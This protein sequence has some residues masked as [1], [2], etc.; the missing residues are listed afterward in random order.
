[1]PS[2]SELLPVAPNN[3]WEEVMT[4]WSALLCGQPL[5]LVQC[6]LAQRAIQEHLTPAEVALI[7]DTSPQALHDSFV[8][9]QPLELED[10]VVLLL[11]RELG[12]PAVAL[13]LGL[14]QL[15]LTDLVSAAG[16]S[17][18]QASL[19][20]RYPTHEAWWQDEAVVALFVVLGGQ[21]GDMPGSERELLA[22][23]E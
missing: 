13:R 23:T 21:F 14:T 19:Q 16:L 6:R 17:R 4:A 15:R 7:L 11:K 20:Q 22:L 9:G 3:R 5:N 1:M 8:H 10:D 2:L 12:L 18:A